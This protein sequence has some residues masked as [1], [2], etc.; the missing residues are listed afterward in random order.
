MNGR[1]LLRLHVMRQRFGG[2]M[3]AGGGLRFG[4]QAVRGFGRGGQ[5]SVRFRR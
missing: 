3:R 2:A 4:P 5:A 1:A